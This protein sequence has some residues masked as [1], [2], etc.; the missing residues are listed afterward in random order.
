MQH[1]T[2]FETATYTQIY[3]KVIV[4]IYFWPTELKPGGGGGAEVQ[5]G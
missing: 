1:L 3:N 4:V 5:E 2:R